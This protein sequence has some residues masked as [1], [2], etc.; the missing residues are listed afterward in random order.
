M[1]KNILK[2]RII[3]F[4]IILIIWMYCVIDKVYIDVYNFNQLR[5]VKKV[6]EKE[7]IL[8]VRNLVDF[9][10]KYNM[11]VKPLNNCYYISNLNWDEPYIFWFKLESSLFLK[12]FGNEYYAYPKYDLPVH[13]VFL[14]LGWWWIDDMNRDKFEGIISNPCED[15]WKLG[16][17]LWF[18]F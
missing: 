17:K 15:Y 3:I 1:D 11:D 16:F 18:I 9:N 12:I 14:W 8:Y 5:K 2:T 10:E 4:L 7:D 13:K 6:F